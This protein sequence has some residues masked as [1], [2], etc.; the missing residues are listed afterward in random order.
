MTSTS[1]YLRIGGKFPH[2]PSDRTQKPFLRVVVIGAGVAGLYAARR[3]RRC[4]EFEPGDIDVRILERASRVGGRV[5]TVRTADGAMEAGAGRVCVPG[6]RLTTRLLRE[7]GLTLRMISDEPVHQQQHRRVLCNTATDRTRSDRARL[8]DMNVL[9]RRTLQRIQTALGYDAEFN[10]SHARGTFDSLCAPCQYATVQEGFGAL[11]TRMLRAAARDGVRVSLSTQVLAVRRGGAEEKMRVRVL[12]SDG[13]CGDIRCDAVVACVPPSSLCAID[14]TG[15]VPAAWLSRTYVRGIP[16]LRVYAKFP[17]KWWGDERRTFDDPIRY[18]IP[19]GSDHIVMVSYTDGALAQ[20][21]YAAH[22]RSPR[23]T[24]RA[25]QRL[26]TRAFHV[27]VPRPEWVRFF[28][29]DTGVHLTPPID[30]QIGMG[31]YEWSRRMSHPDPNTP[32]YL[33]NEAYSYS[34]QQWVEGALRSARR[35]VAAVKRTLLTQGRSSSMQ[36]R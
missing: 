12:R 26:L 33:A 23:Q 3:L 19:V 11:C 30:P 25:L 16:L 32:L 17:H 36:C 22:R 18:F 28:Y 24:E 34:H 1:R 10:V 9:P 7:H 14:H 31:A 35:A 4:F 15:A 13:T 2:A 8:V 29:W 27:E 21:W 5:R 20:H 6:H